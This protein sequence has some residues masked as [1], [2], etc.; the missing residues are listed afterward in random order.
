[1]DSKIIP[2]LPT[3][4][5]IMV[6]LGNHTTNLQSHISIYND[7]SN[8]I[9]NIGLSTKSNIKGNYTFILPRMYFELP[10][11]NYIA[12][13]KTIN[14]FTYATAAFYI[15]PLKILFSGINHTLGLLDFTMTMGN[16]SLSNINYTA[17]LNGKYKQ[18]GTLMGGQLT[19]ILPKGSSLPSGRIVFKFNMLSKTF[20]FILHNTN[21]GPISNTQIILLGVVAAVVL[22]LI[23]L[24]KAPLRD[25]FYIDVPELPPH[26]TTNIQLEKES[27]VSTFNKLNSY[28]HWKYMP[29]SVIEVRAAISNYIRHNNMPVNLTLNNVDMLLTQLI[30]NGDVVSADNLYIPKRWIERTGHDIIY[31]ATFKKL[32]MFLVTHAILFTDL[33][34]SDEADM[35][36]SI[37]G[38]KHLIIIN[39][40]TSKFKKIPVKKNTITYLVFL[41]RMEL[42]D[43]SEKLRNSMSEEIEEFRIYK[44]TEYIKLIDADNPNE[45]IY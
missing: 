17:T 43:F 44:S 13:I 16:T 21:N 26:K 45:I 20:P 41:N 35:V 32:R 29:L 11:G 2:G 37:H 40:Y 23:T 31:L 42:Y 9:L 36:I 5:T 10:P 28:Y 8:D 4:L 34:T 14:N 7:T 3:K 18:N 15:P 30:G 38:E 25:D 6:S 27:V 12:K 19:Y 22:A 33:D 39:S 24:I 1:M